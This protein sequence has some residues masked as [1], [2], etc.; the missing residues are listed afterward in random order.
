MPK[1][2]IYFVGAGPG[3]PALITL[4]GAQILRQADCVI[5]DGLVSEA[6]L[7]GC[8]AD[9]EKICVRKRTGEHPF[10][11]EQIHQLL[12][13]K[14]AQCRTVVRLKGGDPNLFGRLAEEIQLCIRLGADFEV[15]PGVTA[16]TAAAACAG[17]F[18]TDRQSSSQVIFVTGQET[19]DK[20]ETAVDWDLL[21]RFRGTIAFYMAM[22]NLAQIVQILLEKGKSPQTPAAVIQNAA[23]PNQRI[24]Y[25]SLE[26]IASECSRQGIEAPAIVLIGPTAVYR[27]EY[28]W[29][30][31]R[32]LFGKTILIT[33]DE[34]GNRRLAGCLRQQ[35]AEVL[36]FASISVHPLLNTDAAA[37][38]LSRLREMDWVVFTSP[39]GV[40]FT[41]E[42]LASLGKDG[43]AFGNAKIACI[44]P[45]T[46][47][48]LAEVGL[49]ADFVPTRFI[50]EALAEELAAREPLEHKKILLLR[51]AIAPDDLPCCLRQRGACV[52]D[53]PIYTV[54]PASP[55]PE[56]IQPLRRRLT[57]RQ[58][59]WILFA[60]SSA[61]EAFF[62]TFPKETVLQ[63]GTRLASIGPA[64][65]RR[66][67]QLGFSPAVEAPVHT[68][69]GLLEAILR[70]YD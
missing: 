50:G 13:Q 11:Q 70:Y 35:G 29:F 19:P 54:K 10:T 56:Q 27:Q 21:A 38:A 60:S 51:S 49:R 61:A 42:G 65:T 39:R 23:G 45:E 14:T 7:D 33:R 16:A 47:R 43:R 52:E 57:Q 59:D 4:R 67:R 48:R 12:I 20:A 34:E 31:R 9:C 26:T 68:A 22:S 44:G 15:V 30:S 17:L 63:S 3:E 8:P 18:L 24:A 40:R 64:T 53:V 37:S 2:K 32:P 25:A 58:I 66:L 55:A 6:L 28:D 1:A 41:F 36:C 46:A 62:Q 5:Y 69:D